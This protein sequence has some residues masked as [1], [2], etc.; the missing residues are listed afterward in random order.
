DFIPLEELETPEK[1]LRKI[2]NSDDIYGEITKLGEK[3]TQLKEFITENPELT[4][5]IIEKNYPIIDK[6]TLLDTLLNVETSFTYGSDYDSR[7]RSLE[8]Y[9]EDFNKNIEALK[10]QKNQKQEGNTSTT[11]QSPQTGGDY[12]DTILDY[13]K[14]HGGPKGAPLSIAGAFDNIPGIENASA[15]EARQ[16]ARDYIEGLDAKYQDY[17]IELRKRMVD[18]EVNSEDPRAALMEAARVITPGEKKKLYTNGKLDKSKV[19]KYWQEYG[20]DVLSNVKNDLQGFVSKFDAAK[21]RSYKF[22]NDSDKNYNTTWGPRVD[23]W[24]EGFDYNN[25]KPGTYYKYDKDDNTYIKSKKATTKEAKEFLDDPQGENQNI[26]SQQ[27]TNKTEDDIQLNIDPSIV[28][29]ITPEFTIFLGNEQLRNN[30]QALERT[31]K[32][33]NSPAAKAL[34]DKFRKGINN[35]DYFGKGYQNKIEKNLMN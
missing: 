1:S 30:Y 24:N 20:P 23:M 27:K 35:D 34:V 9:R 16:M 15:S 26:P 32:D 3:T 13:E 17:P 5:K 18:F 14:A 8:L 2:L 28:Q 6:E 22:T 21:H 10:A 25:W 31:F 11:N 29:D 12:I 4:D 7:D 19:D 33:P